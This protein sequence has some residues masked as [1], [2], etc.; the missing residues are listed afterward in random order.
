ME[1]DKNIKL[2]QNGHLKDY[3]LWSKSLA[4]QW[5]SQDGFELTSEHWLILELVR[6]IYLKTETTPPMR[7]LIRT[8]KNQLGEE[9]A[10]SRKLYQIC[11]VKWKLFF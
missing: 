8:I 7:L 10:S 5:A 1:I 2:D 9:L 6:E 4:L 3:K 11:S